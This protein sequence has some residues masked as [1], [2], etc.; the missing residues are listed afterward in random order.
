VVVDTVTWSG[1][2]VDPENKELKLLHKDI[3]ALISQYF[4]NASNIDF[5]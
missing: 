5:R 1:L 4:S 3:N 2:A